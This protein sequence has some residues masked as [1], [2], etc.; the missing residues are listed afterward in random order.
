MEFDYCGLMTAKRMYTDD[1]GWCRKVES[2][3]NE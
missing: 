1:Y 2:D 3:K